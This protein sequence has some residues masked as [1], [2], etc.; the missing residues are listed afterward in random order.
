HLDKPDR[1]L[2]GRPVRVGRSPPGT[3]QIVLRVNRAND[4]CVPRV[5]GKQHAASSAIGREYL[6][7]RYMPAPAGSL[8]Q[9]RSILVDIEEIPVQRSSIQAN[10]DRLTPRDRGR[11]QPRRA[12]WRK[13]LD[14]PTRFPRPE[15]PSELLQHHF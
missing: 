4:I 11:R 10:P 7:A 12:N 1:V 13:T 9:K 5:D 15:M 6:A 8:Q 2:I 3:A 14:L